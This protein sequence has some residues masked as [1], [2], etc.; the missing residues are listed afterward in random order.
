M[1]RIWQLIFRFP[2]SSHL[3]NFYLTHLFS[4]FLSF[5][6][7]SL[8]ILFQTVSPQHGVHLSGHLQLVSWRDYR[9]QIT[10][11]APL[12]LT[13]NPL[14]IKSTQSFPRFNCC[15]QIDL[16]SFQVAVS[17]FELIRSIRCPTGFITPPGI[18]ADTTQILQLSVLLQLSCS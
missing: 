2:S 15:T 18:D 5:L 13:V 7:F 16:L 1:F 10:T 11:P 6:Y 17:Y 4:L 3:S 14:D 9:G 8:W 12:G